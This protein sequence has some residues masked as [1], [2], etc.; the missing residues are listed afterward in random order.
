MSYKVRQRNNR[1]DVVQDGRS[2]GFIILKEH[3]REKEKSFDV[4]A[5]KNRFEMIS[6]T[7]LWSIHPW[8]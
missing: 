1:G 4:E 7:D 3:G 6:R 8:N 2:F 5:K